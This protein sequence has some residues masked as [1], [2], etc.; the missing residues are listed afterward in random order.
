MQPRRSGSS[1]V[2]AASVVVPTFNRRSELRGLL[3][4]AQKQ[5]A[6]LEIIVVDDGSTDGTAEM[7]RGEF[8]ETSYERFAGPNGPSF[9]RNRG[10]QRAGAPILFFLDDDSVLT[11]PSTIEQTV[12]EFEHP[13]VGAVGIPFVNARHDQTVW[14]RAPEANAIYATHAFV[15]A[16]SAVR[17]DV[18]VK[19]GGFREHFFY[20]GEEGD[21]CIRML[22]Q[23]YVVR[24]GCA[25]PI[26]HLESG[27]RHLSRAGF[28]GRRNDILF[29]WHNLPLRYL[30]IHILGT[31]VKGMRTALTHGCFCPM[32]RGTF[33]GYIGC[34]KYRRERE[35]VSASIYKLHR[36]LKKKGP[37]RLEELEQLLV[38]LRTK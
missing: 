26:H 35:P 7:M 14:Q 21:F 29:A 30:P 22:N 34:W 33:S 13:H 3:Y 16:A 1:E 37:A 12:A 38:P 32:L 19:L 8:P 10:A 2:T 31:T 5:T 36:R 17:R 11:S 23:G 28:S 25:D 9:L 27:R 24:L 20:M 18:F 6:S 15:G 4:S